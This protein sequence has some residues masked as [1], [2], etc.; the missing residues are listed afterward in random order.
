MTLTF[1]HCLTYF[2]SG[3]VF[4]CSCSAS[5]GLN[6]FSEQAKP[7]VHLFLVGTVDNDGIKADTCRVQRSHVGK[8]SLRLL[9]LRQLFSML[10]HH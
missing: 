10:I 3:V 6:I 9:F 2:H 5:I 1:K 7:Q 4:I 8:V